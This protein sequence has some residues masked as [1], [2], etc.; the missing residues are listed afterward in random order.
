MTIIV[1]LVDKKNKTI[2]MG[3]DSAGVGGNYDLRQRKDVKVFIN[4]GFIIGYTTS[5]RMGQLLRFRFKPPK[6]EKGVSV[7]EYMCTDFIDKAREVFKAGGFATIADSVESGGTF[8]VGV[9]NRL[10]EIQDDFQ[11]A[12]GLTN[13]A[14]CGC[15]EA[16]AMGSLHSTHHLKVSSDKRVKMALEAAQALSAGVRGP[17]VIERLKYNTEIE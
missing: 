11:V 4:N 15:G 8:L 6:I 16:V 9:R 17:F 10:F 2:Y 14:A 3:G 12:E 5:F 7:Y 1:G 13:Y